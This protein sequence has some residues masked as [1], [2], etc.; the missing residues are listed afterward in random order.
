MST[1]FHT[2]TTQAKNKPSERAGHL[3]RDKSI[4]PFPAASFAG[5]VDHMSSITGQAVLHKDGT[6]QLA[7]VS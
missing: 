3:V 1:S 5:Y 2:H 4:K 7:S 6:R